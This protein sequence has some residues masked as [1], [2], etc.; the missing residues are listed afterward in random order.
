MKYK[1]ILRHHE[2]ISHN[3]AGS[4]Q[5]EGLLKVRH[6]VLRIRLSQLNPCGRG[7]D[8]VALCQ[9]RHVGVACTTHALALPTPLRISCGLP[10]R[11]RVDGHFGCVIKAT[12]GFFVDELEGSRCVILGQPIANVKTWAARRTADHHQG[13]VRVQCRAIV[14]LAA[15]GRRRKLPS[16]P[17]N[18]LDVRELHVVHALHATDGLDWLLVC[19]STHSDGLDT[20]LSSQFAEDGAG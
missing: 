7:A 13:I 18:G 17:G 6:R 15:H 8:V 11:R 19:S 4:L 16:S 14:D 12:V 3:V 20:D 5:L 10:D 2:T 1:E 9:C